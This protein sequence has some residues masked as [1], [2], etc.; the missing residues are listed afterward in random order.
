MQVLLVVFVGIGIGE[1]NTGV[2]VNACIAL[3]VTFA[4]AALEREY[5]LPMD[6]GLTLWVCSAVFLHVLGTVG[7]PGLVES[8]YGEG[9]PLPFYDHVTHALSASVVAATGYTVVRAVEEHTDTVSL[10]PRFTFVFI[11]MFVLAFGVL[12]EVVEFA[13]SGAATL[14]GGGSVLTQYGIEDTMLDLVF[15]TVGG[16]VAAVWGTAHLTDVASAL[17]RR[18]D[19]ARRRDAGE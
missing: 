5:D 10:P 6:A 17:T 16:V 11:L 9:S 7:V 19:G 1:G 12:W 3:G 13:V 4:P 15:N 14:V 2:I 18:L 8:F